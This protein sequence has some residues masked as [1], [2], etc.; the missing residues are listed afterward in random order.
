MNLSKQRLKSIKDLIPKDPSN[1]EAINEIVNITEIEH[2]L[3]RKKLVYKTKN[4]TFNFQ[5][6]K[7]IQAF[8]ENIMNG[9]AKLNIADQA[10]I[11]LAMI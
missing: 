4:K 3:I 9:N 1:Q 5:K 8:R 2:Q 7:T 11:D 6:L 10:Q